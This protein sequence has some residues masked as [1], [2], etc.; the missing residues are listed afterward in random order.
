MRLRT[1]WLVLALAASACGAP[2]D[3]AATAGSEGAATSGSE[4]AAPADGVYGRVPRAV[5]GVPSVVLL[6]AQDVPTPARESAAKI[7][8]FGLQFSPRFLIAP[9][10]ESMSFR[11]SESIAHNVMVRSVASSEMLLNADT[12]PGDSLL[13]VLEEPGGYDVACEVHPGMT[14]FIYATNATYAAFAETDGAFAIS[15]VPAGEYT[16]RV[17]SVDLAGRS[18]RT[19]RVSDGAATE[20]VVSPT[21]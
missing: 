14:A 4:G 13:F 15:G 19:V 18:E 6:E 5:G 1:P 7:D 17:W 12:P 3:E 10:G 8:Q 11:N 16:M 2:A 21:G 9:V 20:V